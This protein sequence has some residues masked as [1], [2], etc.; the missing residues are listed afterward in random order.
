MKKYLIGL[1]FCFATIITVYPLE[2]ND[3]N[4]TYVG[5]KSRQEFENLGGDSNYMKITF[6]LS[7]DPDLITD[8]FFRITENDQEDNNM[9]RF[10]F[11]QSRKLPA[12]RDTEIGETY[13]INVIRGIYSRTRSVDGWFIITQ[14]NNSGTWSY[15]LYYF[16]QRL[17]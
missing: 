7:R 12:V 14:P 15:Y 9:I 4:V 13:A 10:V 17:P 3:I 8:K 11:N 5:R 6:Q 2:R 16:S 1:F